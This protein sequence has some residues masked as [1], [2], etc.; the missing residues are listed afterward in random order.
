MYLLRLLL[1]VQW[2][3]MIPF[4]TGKEA[5]VIHDIVSEFAKND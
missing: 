3:Q 5:V 4:R 2:R 1:N